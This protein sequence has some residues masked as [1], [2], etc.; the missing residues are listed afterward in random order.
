MRFSR[1]RCQN[2]AQPVIYIYD[3]ITKEATPLTAPNSGDPISGSA[4][5]ISAD[6]QFITMQHAENSVLHVLVTDRNGTIL[7]DISSTGGVNSPNISANGRFVTFWSTDSK[8]E[9][10]GSVA[11]TSSAGGA[12]EL[13]VLDRGT[14]PPT[15]TPVAVLFSGEPKN[16]AALETSASMSAD[17][18]FIVFA[19]DAENPLVPGGPEGHSNI[20]IYDQTTGQIRNLS[21]ADHGGA[22]NGDSIMPQISA[23]D[24][25][26]TFTSSASNLVAN[27]TNGVA[28]TYLYNLTTNTLTLASA[29][30]KGVPGNGASSFG[31]AVST[32]GIIVSLA[33]L[34]SNLKSSTVN[35]YVVDES[36]GT[37]GT[38]VDD[39]SVQVLTTSGKLYFS[40]TAQGATYTVSVAAQAGA[41][42]TLTAAVIQAPT[43]ATS[44]GQLEWTYQRRRGASGDARG[45]AV[46]GEYLFDRA[47]RRRGRGHQP[48]RDRDHHRYPASG[49]RADLLDQRGRR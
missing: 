27:N 9:V 36:G 35:L 3:R 12:A 41:E 5:H 22:A 17:G 10:N 1:A 31:S 16:A 33:S 2:G 29:N 39:P 25:F 30:A 47:Q 13:Y 48:E 42:G 4:A 38:V 24:R 43:G 6:G 28:Q 18:R 32:D 26:V 34:T 15:V 7:D 14:N 21:S 23:D 45:R 8:I 19:S 20:F 37:A 44:N 11:G 49:H 46:G 40:D